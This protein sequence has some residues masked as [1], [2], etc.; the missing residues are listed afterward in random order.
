MTVANYLRLWAF[1]IVTAQSQKQSITATSY[2]HD[3]VLCRLTGSATGA[4]AA[5]GN[6]KWLD[7]SGQMIINPNSEPQTSS[8]QRST[9]SHDD[10]SSGDRI[11]LSL[12]H[13]PLSNECRSLGQLDRMKDYRSLKGVF[14][15]STQ[16][17]LCH[18]ICGRFLDV[19]TQ[20]DALG[21][22]R[23]DQWQVFFG[24]NWLRDWYDRDG[25]GADQDVPEPMFVRLQVQVIR[26]LWRL[27]GSYRFDIQ[28]SAHPM[29]RMDNASSARHTNDQ[30]HENEPYVGR[31]RPVVLDMSSQRSEELLLESLPDFLCLGELRGRS[32]N[33]FPVGTVH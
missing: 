8:V 15:T 26:P 7:Q 22:D 10:G 27:G 18:T 31:Q 29:P 32:L 23:L 33:R 30:C 13:G 11:Q 14:A 5:L 3:R 2:H 25:S 12:Q 20:R 19:L 4:Q 1:M 21:L 24:N 28:K 17:V 9:Q 16:C 6:I